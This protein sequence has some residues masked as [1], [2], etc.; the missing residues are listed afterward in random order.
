[1]GRR[2]R[3]GS[4]ET[5]LV[6]NAGA[7]RL[8]KQ[9]P[10]QTIWRPLIPGSLSKGLVDAGNGIL[11]ELSNITN[12]S[13]ITNLYSLYRIDV[14]DYTWELTT[15][16]L[17]GVAYPRL[18]VAVDYARASI[19]K[20]E[21]EVLEYANPQV[22]QFGPEATKFTLRFSPRVA[23]NAFQ[24]GVSSGYVEPDKAVWISTGNT[25]VDHYGIKYWLGDYNTTTSSA[26]TIRTYG[27]YKL[28]L[29]GVK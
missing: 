14:I 25:G 29:K 23:M 9:P 6:A 27:R 2:G 22:K 17:S 19:P 3:T 18:V 16:F 7:I 13:E 15:P 4:S 5:S 20:T 10:V 8:Y 11:F 12:I 28:S 26:A 1:M 24:S 21:K